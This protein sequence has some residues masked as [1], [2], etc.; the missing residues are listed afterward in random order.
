VLVGSLA[1]VATVN[2]VDDGDFVTCRFM[3][4]HYSTGISLHGGYS[5][6]VITP[7]EA[8]ATILDRLSA[9]EAAPLIC[10]GV[11]TYNALRNS[12]ARDGDLVAILVIGESR[13]YVCCQDGF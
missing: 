6:Y 10:A 3:Q 11:T 7:A 13:H 2:H 12:G 9:A 8:L 5:E 4:V 1:A